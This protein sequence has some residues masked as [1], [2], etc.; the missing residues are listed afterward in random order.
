MRRECQDFSFALIET[1]AE[2]FQQRRPQAKPTC[3]YLALSTGKKKN[4][5]GVREQIAALLG[6][7]SGSLAILKCLKRE[8]DK[9]QC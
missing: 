2:S 4:R 6:S 8:F 1:R 5:P 9:L 7:G 3:G